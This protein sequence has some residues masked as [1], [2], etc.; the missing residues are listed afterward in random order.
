M[1]PEIYFLRYARPCADF[2]AQRKEISIND[3]KRLDGMLSGEIAPDR[4]YIEKIF[5]RA[6]LPLQRISCNY[7]SIPVLKKYF[8]EEHNKCIDQKMPGFEHLTG[9]QKELCKVYEAEITNVFADHYE[10]F[11]SGSKKNILKGWVNDAKIGDSVFVHYA[12]AVEKR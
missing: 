11:Y 5:Y 6:I 4:A 3:L 8:H 7:W 9:F 2:M 1:I 12:M 10:A